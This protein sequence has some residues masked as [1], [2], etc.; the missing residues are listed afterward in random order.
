MDFPPAAIVG[1]VSVVLALPPAAFHLLKIL[2]RG[3][4]VCHN[5]LLPRFTSAADCLL[6]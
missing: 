1:I 5:N 2:R 3:T 6:D 4:Q